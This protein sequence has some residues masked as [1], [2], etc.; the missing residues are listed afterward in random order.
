MADNNDIRHGRRVL[1]ELL[2]WARAELDK[3]G[4]K[5]SFKLE[6]A[7][8]QA[9]ATYVTEDNL[10]ALLIYRAPRG[11]WHAD[12]LFKKVPPGVPNV[13]G[14]PVASPCRTRSE[15]EEMAKRLL[16]TVLSIAR[17]NK[18][19]SPADP[20]FKLYDYVFTIP[21][22]LLPLALAVM[23]EYATGYGS[24]LQAS[25][26]VEQALEA[27]CPEGFDGATFSDWPHDKKAKL[28]AVLAISTL[29]GL[30]VYPMRQHGP[31]KDA[32]DTDT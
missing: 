14:T 15:A 2:P 4:D 22:Q 25:A 5:V 12:V 7:L 1:E 30:Y 18:A 16:V 3:L 23:P 11:G 26:R 29:S 24:P 21:P 27:L 28:L 6:S 13:M 31:P 32:D 17:Q 8:G 9:T 20:V 10:D 19:P